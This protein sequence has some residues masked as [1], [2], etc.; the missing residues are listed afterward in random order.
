MICKKGVPLYSSSPGFEAAPSGLLFK[1]R[2]PRRPA[3]GRRQAEGRKKRE[4]MYVRWRRRQ[5]LGKQKWE[6]S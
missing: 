6:S 3:G 4:R 5:T 1:E 2:S